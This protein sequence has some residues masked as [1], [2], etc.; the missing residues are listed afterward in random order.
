[1]DES[2]DP[3][4]CT[5][6]LPSSP[7]CHMDY[8]NVLKTTRR[9]FILLS[10]VKTYLMVITFHHHPFP[11]RHAGPAGSGGRP[12]VAGSVPGGS[13]SV[14]PGVE[15]LPKHQLARWT[16]R[17]RHQSR[18]PPAENGPPQEVCTHDL[19]PVPVNC[20]GSPSSSAHNYEFSFYFILTHFVIVVIKSLYLVYLVDHVPH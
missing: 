4:K 10:F 14:S 7:G 3:L 12:E 19:W 1:M 17:H 15:L 5:E 18:E 8:G 6:D 20:R 13:R 11:R 16:R 2:F 9:P